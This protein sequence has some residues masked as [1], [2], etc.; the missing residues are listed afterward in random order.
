MGKATKATIRARIEAVAQLILD[1]ALPYQVRQWV[2]EREAAGEPPWTIP[3]GGKP[4]SERQIAR[5][6]AQA[7]ALNAEEFRTKRTR[8]LRR[9]LA[10]RRA[11]FARCVNS[12]DWRTALAS[13]DSEARLMGL[14]PKEAAPP[15]APG[16]VIIGGVDA[17]AA[18]G[19]KPA[20]ESPS[21]AAPP[22]V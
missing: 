15:A 2:S 10:K 21:A 9:H 22:A 16:V 4:L 20:P 11:L 1:G 14:F 3:E 13:L 5:Y 8:M 7:D 18:L 6:A 12:G 17:D 19:R